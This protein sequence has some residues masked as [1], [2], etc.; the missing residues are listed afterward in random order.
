MIDPLLVWIAVA[1]TAALFAHA[2]VAKLADRALFAQHLAAYGVPHR[3][4]TP[5]GWLIPAAEVATAVAL[6]T[7]ARSAGAAA[8]AALLLLYAAVM[9]WHR[10]RGSRLDCGCGGEPLPLSWALV[11]R[12]LGLAG[13]ALLAGA[14]MAPRA[15]SLA[16][17]FVIA[18]ALVLA[19]LLHAALHQMLR[20]RARLSYRS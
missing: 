15:L 17:F 14:P 11:L 8:A 7:P 9:A 18:A 19:T 12:N 20:H 5:A 13:L 2:A 4:L 1:C 16:D 10:G 6:L 3:L